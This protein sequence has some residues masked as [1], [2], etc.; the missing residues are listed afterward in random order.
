MNWEH[1]H[2]IT[3]LSNAESLR[4]MRNLYPINPG[5]R[6]RFTGKRWR[7]YMTRMRESMR[8]WRRAEHL[9]RPR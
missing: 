8:L 7:R 5:E 9:M 4:A 2:R 1:I 6:R 3:A